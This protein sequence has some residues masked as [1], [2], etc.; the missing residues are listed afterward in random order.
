M[1]QVHKDLPYSSFTTP[2]GI[3][4]ATVCARSGKQPIAGLCDGT[5]ISEYFEEGTV[6]TESCDVHYG[7]TICALDGLPATEQCPYKAQGVFELTPEVPP[8]LQSGFVNYT[9]GNSAYTTT[10]NENGET[11]MVLNQCR[12]TPEYMQQEGIEGIIQGEWQLLQDAAAAAAAAAGE[13]APAE[14]P[15]QETV[16]DQVPENVA[17]GN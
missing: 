17:A 15:A 13:G 14:Q 4:S 8:A 9:P 3:V 16:V 10:T 12:H 2:S 7:G 6:P 5:L 1:E 11:V